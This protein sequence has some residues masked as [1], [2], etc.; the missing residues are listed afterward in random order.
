MVKDKDAEYLRLIAITDNL[1]G[2]VDGLRARAQ[3]ARRGGAT[4]IQIRLPDESARTL[5]S[6]TRALVS[7]LDI[8]VVVH[9]RI[10]VALAA[11]ARGVHLGV[12]DVPVQDA[13]RICAKGLIVGRS[14]ATLDDLALAATADYVTLGPVFAS[15]ARRPS[16]FLGI[17]NFE[18]L[19]RAAAVP[20]VAIGG[21]TEATVAE[22]MR[23]GAT[24]VAL[25]SG[26]LGASDP[27]GAARALRSAIGT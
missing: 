24:G 17:T 14:A 5:V 27:E 20:V 13:R 18:R 26:I 6:L 7:T 8:P 22:V 4:M 2:G 16:S 10:D 11:G 1:R 25:I 9:G 15:A 12:H 21:I 19:A 3:A 23:A